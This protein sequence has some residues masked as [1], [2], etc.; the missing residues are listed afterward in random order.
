M[1]RPVVLWSIYAVAGLLP[2]SGLVATA[3][4]QQ[5]LV[6]DSRSESPIEI[7]LSNAQCKAIESIS[8][9]ASVPGL[10]ESAKVREG[11][12]VKKGDLLASIEDQEVRLKLERAIIA[13]ESADRKSRNDIDERLAEKSRQVAEAE[14][15]HVEETNSNGSNTYPVKEVRRLK[16]VLDRSE[17]ELERAELQQEINLFDLQLAV[18]E[19]RQIEE[20]LAKHQILAPCD[21]MV[22]SVEKR[23]GEWLEAGASTFQIVNTNPIRIEGFI[24]LESASESL[25]GTVA[26]VE[27]M[28]GK[29]MHRTTA[30]V[31]FLSLDANPVNG[32]VRVFLEAENPDGRLR[33][34]MRPKAVLRP[35]P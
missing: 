20:R 19:C 24:P 5:P 23:P 10:L 15:R 1:I 31:V 26:D 4:G 28:Q 14:Y 16:L 32:E 27:V 29:T 34:G 30:R 33:P 35:T 2:T 11:S 9:A 12:R 8:V 6:Q 22:V 21:G 18:N 17:L 25:L 3:W 7:T 13:R